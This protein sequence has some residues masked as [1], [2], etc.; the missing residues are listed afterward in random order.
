MCMSDQH[1]HSQDIDSFVQPT[2]GFKT[3]LRPWVICGTFALS[4]TV[5]FMPTPEGLEVSGQRA[6]AIFLLCFIFWLTN[7]V[8]LVIT[9]LFAIILLPLLG[10]LDSK[11][12]YALFGNQA[13]FFIL[14]AFIL[15]SAMMQSGLSTRVA[16]L[17]LRLF[18]RG[19][20]SLVMGL[21]LIP[22]GL[23]FV[24]SEHAVAALFFPIVLDIAKHLQLREGNRYGMALFFAVTWGSIIG[25]IATFLGGARALL[26]VGIMEE[27]TGQTVAFVPWMLAALPTVVLMLVVAAGV[28]LWM[29]RHEQ[30]HFLRAAAVVE[31]TLSGLGKPSRREYA[32]ALLMILTIAAWIF[33]GHSVGLAT[34]AIGAVVVAFL[35]KLMSWKQVERHVNW[36]IFL[37]YGGAIALG[38]AL[39]QSGAAQWL[40]SVV[41]DHLALTPLLLFVMLAA[42]STAL[43]EGIS[44]SAVIA[45][46]LPVG[47][48]LGG[49]LGISPAIITLSIA[50]PAGL[51]FMLPISTPANALA[52]S[53]RYVST[54]TMLTTGLFLN[55]VAVVIFILVARFYWPLIGFTW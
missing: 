35:F 50:I 24:M 8:P 13:V 44:N 31:S 38:F 15:A 48:A 10:V 21:L 16:L 36:G 32:I 33:F 37:M 19:R 52:V 51:A 53:S 34:I 2:H 45:V 4:A 25:G 1:A 7:A 40:T 3:K 20:T 41:M 22:A 54:K 30:H 17:L 12:S 23:S 46:L 49:T 18:N 27:T 11:T 55:T 9:S 43:T 6:I 47:L 28:L 42:L 39:D 29:I 14:G 5:A 26:A